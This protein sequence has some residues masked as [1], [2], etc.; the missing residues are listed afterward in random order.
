MRISSYAVARPAYYDR[1]SSSGSLGYASGGVPPHADTVRGTATIAAGK[2]AFI[3]STSLSST[4]QAAAT[5]L[6]FG[7]IYASY[8]PSG[9]GANVY[10][11]APQ[12]NN[13]VGWVVNPILGGSIVL[14]TGD[15]VSIGTYDGSTGGT[16]SYYMYIRYMT[17]DA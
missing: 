13:T 5:T 12:Q 11:L 16:I 10:L 8:T 17:F 6:A 4:R 15:A 2:K 14:N 1:N 7:Y 3:D 9:G